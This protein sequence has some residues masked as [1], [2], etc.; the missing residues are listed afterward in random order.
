MKWY[1]GA[2]SYA[3]LLE[4]DRRHWLMKTDKDLEVQDTHTGDIFQGRVDNLGSDIILETSKLN[5]KDIVTHTG[6]FSSENVSDV[7]SLAKSV[8]QYIPMMNGLH[9]LRVK[10]INLMVETTYHNFRLVLR[11]VKVAYIPIAPD[12]N[13]PDV[14]VYKW[15]YT[16]SKPILQSMDINGDWTIETEVEFSEGVTNPIYYYPADEVWPPPPLYKRCG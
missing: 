6:T 2:S 11:N 3:M 1:L 7:F 8:F 13:D 14:F 9:F 15:Y 5:T 12:K 4:Q 16:T 10:S